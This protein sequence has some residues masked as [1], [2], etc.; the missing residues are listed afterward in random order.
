MEKGYV[1]LYTGNGKGKTTAALG[2]ALRAAGYNISSII[3]QF[4]KGQEYGELSSV[5]MLNGLITVEQYGSPDFC[6]LED[7]NIRDHYL[8]ARKGVERSRE[9]IVSDE[10]NIVVLDEIVTAMLFKLVTL[11]EI[12][13]LIKNKAASIELILTGRGATD[14]LISH[15]DLVTEMKEIKH[16]YGNGIPA[17][18]GIEY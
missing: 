15:C 9:V 1:H 2:M 17:R 12:I 14:T 3:I 6:R 10:Y 18:K 5:K 8:L 16:Y 7:E 13:S 4:M 11:D